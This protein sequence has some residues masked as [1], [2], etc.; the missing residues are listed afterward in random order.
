MHC[1]PESPASPLEAT[2]VP[3]S[4]LDDV[5]DGLFTLLSRSVDAQVEDTSPG[6]RVFVDYATSLT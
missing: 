1:A 6:K 5:N 4:A 2:V 3:E